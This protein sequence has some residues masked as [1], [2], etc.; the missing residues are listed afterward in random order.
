MKIIYLIAGSI[1]ISHTVLSQEKALTG[2]ITTFETIP[3]VNASILVKSSGMKYYS[4]SLG[5]FNV[6]CSVTDKL[7]LSAEGFSNRNVNVK[8]ETLFAVVNMVLLPKEDAKDIAVGYGHVKEKDKLY[9]MAGM[10]ESGSNFSRYKNIYE[11]LSVSF[12]GVQ[13]INGEVIIRNANSGEG[14]KPALLIVD[15]REVS[16]ASLAA[17]NT[18]DIAQISILKDA[19]A[20]VYGVQGAN[21]VVLVE[22]KR[23]KN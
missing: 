17:I 22:T 7:V 8:K 5:I 10:S 18:G 15:G 14:S 6:K 1:L 13:V 16:A 4:D 3:V 12:A 23:G 21:G 11:I 19:S 9:A 2:K 20:S